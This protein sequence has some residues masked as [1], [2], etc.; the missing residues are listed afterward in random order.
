MTAPIHPR[1][2][3]LLDRI[4]QNVDRDEPLYQADE[5]RIPVT[6]YTDEQRFALERARL[7]RRVPVVVAHAS[8]VAVPGA[9]ITRTIAGISVVIVRGKDGVLRGFL[10]ACRH[11]ATELVSEPACHKN[12]LVCPYHNWAYDLTGAL[13]DVPHQR[14][15]PSLERDELGLVAVPVEEHAG[16]IWVTARPGDDGAGNARPDATPDAAPGDAAPG[17]AA[18]THSVARFLG[19]LAE[20]LEALELADHIIYRRFTNTRRANWKL[21]IELFI[22]SY[23]VRFLHRKSVYPYFLDAASVVERE[24]PHFRALSARRALSA[25]PDQQREMGLRDLATPS[26]LIFPNT[27]FVVHQDFV[28]HLVIWPTAVDHFQWCHTMLIPEEPTTDSARR[29]WETNVTL[30][31]ERVFQGED[32]ATAE[33]MQRGLD[34]GANRELVVGQLESP[35]AWFHDDIAA[36]IGV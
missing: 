31:E 29:H 26:Y 12:A 27:I 9:C 6:N 7:F 28:S 11:R 4:R 5:A 18:A 19:P 24:R 17:E 16:L 15:F 25:P 34:T 2:H 1:H 13:I 21:V 30:I 8:D 14:A 23:H 3:A 10:N 35:I 33:A 22:E 36:A 20:E 32:L